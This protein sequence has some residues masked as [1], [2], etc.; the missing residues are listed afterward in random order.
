[1]YLKRFFLVLNLLFNINLISQNISQFNIFY[2]DTKDPVFGAKVLFYKGVK[3]VNNTLSDENGKVE[4]N[5]DLDFEYLEIKKSGY[6]IIS[7]SKG[8][9]ISTI[10]LKPRANEIDEVVITGQII[11][12]NKY[13]SPFKL[14]FYSK[15]EIESKNSVNLA[16]FLQTENNF[17]ITQDAVLGTKV[18]LNGMNGQDLKILIDGIPVAG[19]LNGTVDFSQI[20]LNNIERIEVVDGPLSVIYGTNS[21]GGVINLISKSKVKEDIALNANFFAESVGQINFNGSISTNKKGNQIR[22]EFGRNVFLG[23]DQFADSLKKT[24]KPIWRDEDWNPK[25]QYFANFS[26]YRALNKKSKL[27]LKFNGFWEDI[28][29]KQDPASAYSEN[30]IDDQYKTSRINIGG[31]FDYKIN[32][33]FELLQSANFTTFIRTTSYY[34]QNL[35]TANRSLLNQVDENFYNFFYRAILRQDAFKTKVK[36]LYGMDL[37]V[38][39]LQ[40][41]KILNQTKALYEVG[42]FSMVNL[43]LNEQ[44]FFQPGLRFANNSLFP[45]TLAPTFNLRYDFS[46]KASVRLSYSHG[47]RNP[48]IKELFFNFVDNNH[49]IQGN[50]NLQTE[51][52]DNVQLGFDIKSNK[53]EDKPHSYSTSFTLSLISKSNAI[54]IVP[55]NVSKNEFQYQNIGKYNSMVFSL[56]NRMKINNIM[57][58]LGGNISGFSRFYNNT[59]NQISQFL[60]NGSINLNCTYTYK[61]W[62]TKFTFLSKFYTT[63]TISVLNITNNRVETSEFPSY[64]MTDFNASR[65]FFDKKLSVTVGVKNILNV[66]NLSVLGYNGN[67]HSAAGSNEVNF[68]WGRSIFTTINLNLSK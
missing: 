21:S 52:N 49:N 50:Q 9:N 28:L 44:L 23:W 65:N 68:L 31:T 46:Q 59:A 15:E 40:A 12:G 42:F 32:N 11:P 10:Y 24:I 56:D 57:F 38:D 55:V 2:N 16:D 19:R 27:H 17:Q 43:Q 26:F 20:L 39:M 8:T 36:V 41:Q 3:I 6:Q 53:E 18:S 64:I 37:N 5:R 61:P 63:N 7:F 33:E 48:E 47:Y 62:S 35:T 34:S 25:E 29:N 58:G 1:M 66:K 54:E 4:F 14:K 67:F 22:L 60:F 51:E 30:V 13:Q 45:S